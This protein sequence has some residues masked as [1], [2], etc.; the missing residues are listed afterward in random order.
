MTDLAELVA[1]H[2]WITLAVITSVLVLLA[3]ICWY[4]LQRWG[5]RVVELSRGGLGRL[6][7]H[8]SRFPAPRMVSSAWQLVRRLGLQALLSVA[9]AISASMVFL[10]IADEISPEEDLGQFDVALSA[11]IGRHASDEQLRTFALLT[12]LGDRA[13]L[14]ALVIVV[15]AL[16][17]WRRQRF[18]AAAWVVASALGGLLNIALKAIFARSRP[19]FVHGFATADGWSFPSGHSSGSMIVYGLLGYLAVLYTPKSIHLPTAA[20]AMTL[21]VCV[22][23]SRVILQVHYFSDVL[24][25]FAV[26]AS[27]VA[28]WIAGLEV[29]RRAERYNLRSTSNAPARSAIR[30]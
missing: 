22:G 27:W 15:A 28:A 6:R 29:L 8:A 10:E 19:E 12:H 9:F 11:A 4:T 1:S 3:W 14:I 5:G 7:V 13:F 25:G 20:I 2:L 23:M 26:G 24:G 21:V 18:M 30:S 16:L 17:I